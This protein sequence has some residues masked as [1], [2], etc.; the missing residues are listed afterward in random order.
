M[1]GHERGVVAHRPQLGGDRLDQLLVIAARK[2][3]AADRS[4]EQ[5]VADDR[6]FLPKPYAQ[7]APV[8]TLRDK[9]C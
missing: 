6:T 3:P 8:R 5:D 4:A 1:A 7:I 2:V 9:L